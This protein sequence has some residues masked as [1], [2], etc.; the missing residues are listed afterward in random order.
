MK[1]SKAATHARREHEM[2]TTTGA[3]AIE[4]RRVADA[5]DK[6][7]E[8]PI[9]SPVLGFYCDSYTANDKGK[10]GFLALARIMPRPLE[11][12]PDDITFRLNYKTDALFVSMQISRKMVCK[13][14]KPAQPAE[15]E[16]E[17]LLS[18]GEE[19][20]LIPVCQPITATVNQPESEEWSKL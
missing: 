11:K 14:V 17:P 7:P 12:K 4:L 2:M 18:D 6:E 3:V 16:C 10:S 19:A 1:S 5:L 8:A 13:L 9:E 15:Y 20:A